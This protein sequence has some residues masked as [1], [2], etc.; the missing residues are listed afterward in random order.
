MVQH[1]LRIVVGQHSGLDAK[2]AE[3]GIGFPSTEQLDGVF[4][5]SCTQQG[6]CAS[7]TEGTGTDELRVD[8]SS[9]RDSTGA[10]SK[11]CGDIG[12]FDVEPLV[13]VGVEVAV[14]RCV[15]GCVEDA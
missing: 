3:H 5:Y 6:G 1:L 7:R 15:D 2:V 8:T 10:C 13:S 9:V 11:G 12:R 14:D 4:V